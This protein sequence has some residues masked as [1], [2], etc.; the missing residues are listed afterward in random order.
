MDTMDYL[1][2]VFYSG[3][4]EVMMTHSK[5][6]DPKEFLRKVFEE[7]SGIEEKM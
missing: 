4:K 5:Y 6:K 3:K 1:V 7:G 2:Y